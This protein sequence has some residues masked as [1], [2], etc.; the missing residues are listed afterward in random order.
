MSDDALPNIDLNDYE[1][2]QEDA[3]PLPEPVEDTEGTE[4]EDNEGA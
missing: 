3:E 2:V 1:K 4:Q